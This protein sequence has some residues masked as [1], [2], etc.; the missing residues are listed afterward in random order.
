ML[1][2]PVMGGKNGIVLPFY[3]HYRWIP[4]ASKSWAPNPLHQVHGPL[5][6]ANSKEG[7]NQVV[8]GAS[9]KANL[10]RNLVVNNIILL[11]SFKLP[12]NKALSPWIELEVLWFK[13]SKSS[14]SSLASSY[15]H[16]NDLALVP[17]SCATSTWSTYRPAPGNPT[18]VPVSNGKDLACICCSKFRAT[19]SWF[20]CQRVRWLWVY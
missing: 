10:G 15:C 12:L 9:A 6:G 18:A 4:K 13:P 7:Q 20:S 14:D 2:F 3:P 5:A 19:R 16:K 1:P 11:L 17:W 8:V